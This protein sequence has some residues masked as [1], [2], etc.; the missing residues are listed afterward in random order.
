M[1]L[2]ITA[3]FSYFSQQAMLALPTAASP[4]TGRKTFP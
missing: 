4:R 1:A 3:T 2:L